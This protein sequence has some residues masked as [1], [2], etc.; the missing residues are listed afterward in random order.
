MPKIRIAYVFG[1]YELII[2]GEPTGLRCRTAERAK[3]LAFSIVK[4]AASEQ[5]L[6]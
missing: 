4:V 3:E 2:D 5:R 6:S 1:R